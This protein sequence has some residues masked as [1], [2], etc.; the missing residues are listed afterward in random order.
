VRLREALARVDSL[1]ARLEALVAALPADTLRVRR[2]SLAGGLAALSTEVEKVQAS[3]GRIRSGMRSGEGNLGRA[4][5]D[6]TLQ[7][8]I[9][10]TRTS[11]R[12]LLEKYTGR[13]SRPR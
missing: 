9:E 13:R 2:D 1:A 12:L 5:R 6:G 3:L 7:R 8:E 10:A 4:R 11:L